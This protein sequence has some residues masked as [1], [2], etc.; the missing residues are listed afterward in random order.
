MYIFYKIDYITRS[1][2]S[3]LDA[4]LKD[5]QYKKLKDSFNIGDN[6]K[7]GAAFDFEL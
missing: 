4:K 3:H 5:D 2:D 7:A 1:K 6:Y